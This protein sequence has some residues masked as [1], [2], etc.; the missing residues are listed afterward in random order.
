M[1]E[2]LKNADKSKCWQRSRGTGT[3]LLLLGK[4]IEKGN[5]E[6]PMAVSYKVNQI[7][8]MLT[9]LTHNPKKNKNLCPHKPPT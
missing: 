7:L 6:N 8:N 9:N 5:A 2:W 4:Q 1:V 3:D